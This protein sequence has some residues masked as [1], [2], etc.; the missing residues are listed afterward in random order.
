MDWAELYRRLECDKND[1]TAWEALELRV[2]AWA[3]PDLWPRGWHMVEDAVADTCST[4]VLGLGKAY[5]AASF[6]GF[7]KG[8]YL[9]VR[10]RLLAV[11]VVTTVSIDGADALIPA[12]D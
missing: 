8:H 2:R 12:L 3:R 11:S 10:R 1:A 5:G 7:V 6:A 4:V 9:N